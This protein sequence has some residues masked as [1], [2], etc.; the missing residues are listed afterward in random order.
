MDISEEIN[1]IA[2]ELLNTKTHCARLSFLLSE[3]EEGEYWRGWGFKSI[4][5]FIKDYSDRCGLKPSQL[6]NYKLVGRYL[7]TFLKE[8]EFEKIGI[9][10][11]RVI[12]KYVKETGKNPPEEVIQ[13]ALVGKTEDVKKALFQKEH[14][15][16]SEETQD[17][18][19]DFGEIQG[20]VSDDQKLLIS[21]AFKAA[22]HTDPV[23]PIEWPEWKRILDAI[24]KMSMEYIAAH[25][26]STV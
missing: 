17:T 11:L 26:E 12:Q 25:P 10:T 16:T 6:H 3:I 14:P 19:Y 20:Y 13:T 23:T 9:T 1:K 22:W 7:K 2:P 4:S 24:Q 8:E 5:D 15:A 21:A 18:W